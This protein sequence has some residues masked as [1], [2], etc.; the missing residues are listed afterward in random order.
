MFFPFA[1]EK[2]EADAETL[3]VVTV[4]LEEIKPDIVVTHW[5][6]DTHPN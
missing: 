4:W 3:N 2:L 1:H 6:L 5:P